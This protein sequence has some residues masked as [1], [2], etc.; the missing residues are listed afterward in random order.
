MMTALYW[1]GVKAYELAVRIA[2][3]W[4]EKAAEAVRRRRGLPG[5]VAAAMRTE[6]RPRIWMHCASLGEFEQGRPVLEALRKEHPH[7]AFVLT[8]FSPSGYRVRKDWEGADYVFYL[9]FDGAVRARKLVKALRPSL[10]IWVKYEFWYFTLRA[11]KNAGVPTVL[12]AGVFSEKAPVFQW[13]GAL[14]R[15]LTQGFD[16]IFTQDEQSRERLSAIGITHTSTAGDP[17]YDR[18]LEAVS[19]LKEIEKAARFSVSRFTIAAGSTWP[20]DEAVL[21]DAMRQLPEE[22]KLLLVP[23]EVGEAHLQTIEARF[24]NDCV[25]WS[26]WDGELPVRVLIVDSV[27]MLMSLYHY[28]EV[29]YVGG[30]FGRAGVHNVLEPAAHGMPVLMGP[31]HHQ[32]I[33]AGELVDSGGAVVVKG[34]IEFAMQALR[35]MKDETTRQA[36]GAAAADVVRRGAGATKK[37]AGKIED[38]GWLATNKTFSP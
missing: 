33:E 2:A 24:K 14:H 16:W 8:F 25:R 37:I 17:R 35:L 13:W 11:L 34:A 15:R 10:A 6:K 3:L 12:I 36:V 9:P 28:A 7:F 30:G 27:G 18:V 26:R 23:H 1:L 20:G 21:V 19:S 22:V 29:A 31:V 32:F 38:A 4:N 5:Q